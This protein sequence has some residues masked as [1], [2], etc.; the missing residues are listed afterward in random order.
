VT[1]TYGALKS[2]LS[3]RVVTVISGVF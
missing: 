3:F 2:P 1:V